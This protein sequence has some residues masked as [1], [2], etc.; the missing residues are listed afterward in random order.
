M[1]HGQHG[2]QH[3]FGDQHGQDRPQIR[4]GVLSAVSPALLGVVL[5]LGACANSAQHAPEAT[6]TVAQQHLDVSFT[7]GGTQLQAGEATR[8]ARFLEQHRAGPG[9]TVQISVESSNSPRFDDTRRQHIAETIANHGSD[10]LTAIDPAPDRSRRAG[11]RAAG[12]QNYARNTDRGTVILAQ[13]RPSAPECR[14]SD[15][16][17]VQFGFAAS[18][19][20][21]CSTARNLAAQVSQPRDLVLG[22]EMGSIS[23][24]RTA[25][26]IERYRAGTDGRDSIAPDPGSLFPVLRRP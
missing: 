11:R 4:S 21:G 2:Q 23:A 25:G 3:R 22:R 5:L 18:T 19:G 7:S 1:P 15:H 6:A 10:V 26:E 24:A 8:L 16:V 13:Y 20:F 9:D 14:P 17:R 12:A